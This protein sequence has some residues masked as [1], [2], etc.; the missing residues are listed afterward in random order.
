MTNNWKLQ[1]R[2]LH[3]EIQSQH[4][5][6]L[7]EE[8]QL[9][10]IKYFGDEAEINL[11]ERN[12]ENFL[13]SNR[14]FDNK[15]V[16]ATLKS[17]RNSIS[18]S[19]IADKNFHRQ[20]RK[21]WASC[22]HPFPNTR[23]S[24][25]NFEKICQEAQELLVQEFGEIDYIPLYDNWQLDEIKTIGRLMETG[26]FLNLCT[27]FY[28]VARDYMDEVITGNSKIWVVRN[29]ETPIYQL[30]IDLDCNVIV[31]FSG[32]INKRHENTDISHELAMNI[33]CTVDTNGDGIL[34]FL[35]AGAL[36]RFK[37]GRPEITPFSIGGKEIWLWRYRDEL[38]LA[39]DEDSDGTLY[40][41]RF[42]LPLPNSNKRQPSNFRNNHWDLHK[43]FN[44]TLQNPELFEQMRIVNC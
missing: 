20:I 12:I 3:K 17:M 19:G 27:K 22:R 24:A 4:A 16:C 36:S 29:S 41:S 15:I 8:P 39:V 14:N 40:W 28:D 9:E 2:Q 10:Y 43:L 37:N 11:L 25:E 32:E 13:E 5:R 34:E 26:K 35:Q 42:E 38:I 7:R 44:L 30:K 23:K 33:L 6:E 18:F 21:L 1:L 31:E